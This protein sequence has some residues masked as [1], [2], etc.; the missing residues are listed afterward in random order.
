MHKVLS[1][2]LSLFVLG[3]ANSSKTTEKETSASFKTKIDKSEIPSLP[4]TIEAKNVVKKNDQPLTIAM[5]GDIMMGTTYPKNENNLTADDGASL[6][7]DASEILRRV[8]IAGGNLEG[9]LFDGEGKIKPCYNPKRFFAFKMPERYSKHLVEAGFD[10]LGVA[11]NHINDFGPE[12]FEATQRVLQE[13]G[14]EYAG[15]S[16]KKP[17][18]IIEKDGRRIGFAAFGF[19]KGMPSI[20][21]YSEIKK[22]VSDLKDQSDIEVVCFHGGGEGKDFQH[23]PH[24][25]E[26]GVRGD[27]EKFA[28]TAVDAGADVVYGHSPH[29]PRALELYKDRIIF[30]SLGNFCTPFRFNLEG[31]NGLAPLAE[32]TV[33]ADGTFDEGKIHSFIQSRGVGPRKDGSHRA[34]KKIQE[35]T[36]ADFPNTPVQISDQGVITRITK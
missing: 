10:F 8:D 16:G 30:Y 29:V 28:H 34:A 21:N 32:V 2:M 27:V 14:L 17:T 3:C 19:N 25:T 35:L 20:D 5:V 4:D 1:I 13:A 31:V 24:R 11:N 22:I 36:K 12:A 15:V 26:L 7:A 6:F 33:N 18:T 23:V 9:C